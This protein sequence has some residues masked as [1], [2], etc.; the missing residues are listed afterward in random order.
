MPIELALRAEKSSTI[1]RGVG[2]DGPDQVYSV[3]SPLCAC[4]RPGGAGTPATGLEGHAEAHFGGR[5]VLTPR[6][7]AEEKSA[8]KDVEAVG[9]KRSGCR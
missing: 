8:A 4:R 2:S 9:E 3:R 1:E 6:G 7:L 5:E